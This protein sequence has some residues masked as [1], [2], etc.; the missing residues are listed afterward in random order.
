MVIVTLLVGASWWSLFRRHL[1]ILIKIRARHNL[2]E[3]FQFFEP[4][5]QKS[6][7]VCSTMLYKSAQYNIME[8]TKMLISRGKIR[9][10]M[11]H[12]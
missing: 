3:Q 9:Q 8:T 5:V 7:H 10:I 11:S 4:L 2:A 12:P 6:V 1:A